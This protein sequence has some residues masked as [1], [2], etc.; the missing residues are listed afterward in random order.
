MEF[1]KTLLALGVLSV[2][3]GCGSDS[4]D[5]QTNTKKE[6]ESQVTSNEIK[7]VAA[8]GTLINAPVTFFKYENGQPVQ[9]DSQTAVITDE[10]GL[11]NATVNNAQ[12]IVK[13]QISVSQDAQNPTYM[14]CDAP[15][16]C[17]QNDTDTIAFGERVNLTQIAPDLVLSTFV[18][19]TEQPSTANITPLT[20]F[21]AAIAQQRG[22]VTPD[23]IAT[24]YSEI[25]DLFGLVGALH[26]MKPAMIED[27]ASLVDDNNSDDLRYA[28]INAG[29]AHALFADLGD[30][31]NALSTR[32]AEAITDIQAT[33]G[34]FLSNSAHDDDASF[35]FNLSDILA[36]AELASQQLITLIKADPALADKLDNLSELE[37]LSTRLHNEM[38][39]AETQ[40]TDRIKG[41]AQQQSGDNAVAK[42]AAMVQDIRVFANLFDVADTHGK[43]VRTQ[44]DEFVALIDDATDMV[45][46]QAN[47]YKLLADVSEALALIDS[48]R[49]AGQLPNNNQ[50]IKLD[51]YLELAGAT[52]MAVIDETG[53]VFSVTASAG[54]EQLEAN[55]TIT[56]AED[57][58]TYTLS[59][60]GKVENN[61]A[62]LTINQ[63][64]QIEVVL[65][66][67]VTVEQLKQGNAPAVD[68][69]HGSLALDVTIAQKATESITV[70]VSFQGMISAELTAKHIE[71]LTQTSLYEGLSGRYNF[72]IRPDTIFVPGMLSLSG[73]FSAAQGNQIGASLTVKLDN[74]SEF[75]PA[76]FEHFG[77]LIPDAGTLSIESD[78]KAKI[79][80]RD[81][82]SLLIEF[83]PVNQ[84]GIA[85]VIT[86]YVK[87]GEDTITHNRQI[88]SYQG[89][90][91]VELTSDYGDGFT[92]KRLE[93]I[94]PDGFGRFELQYFRYQASSLTG[95]ANGVVTFESGERI[96]VDE[97]DWRA[98]FSSSDE[99]ALKKLRRFPI[100][101]TRIE[102]IQ[103]LL[104]PEHSGSVYITKLDDIYVDFQLQQ[105]VYQAG[106]NYPLSARYLY[107]EIPHTIEVDTRS[108]GNA[109]TSTLGDLEQSWT[110]SSDND[111]AA[112]YHY[113]VTHQG[114]P[115]ET[116]SVFVKAMTQQTDKNDLIISTRYFD[117]FNDIDS[118]V[119]AYLQPDASGEGYTA[120]FTQ[121]HTL[122]EQGLPIDESGSYIDPTQHTLRTVNYVNYMHA[123][124]DI[125]GTELALGAQGYAQYEFEKKIYQEHTLNYPGYGQVNVVYYQT[126]NGEG[127][128]ATRSIGK[129]NDTYQIET[130]TNYLDISAAMNVNVKLGE[131]HVDLSLVGQRTDFKA[132]ELELEVD[133]QVPG[134]ELKRSFTVFYNTETEQ[135]SANNAEGV[136]LQMAETHSDD[137]EG[138][139]TLGTIMVG[140]EQAARIVK[141][142]AGLFI[143]YA[144]EQIE[145]L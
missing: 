2:L 41:Q 103:T 42:A 104:T 27:S 37:K 121:P 82:E 54:E 26:Q 17:G 84:Q 29:I 40:N 93:R 58:Q 94:V 11:F 113:S 78:S 51:D 73:T 142:D 67:P 139:Q 124:Q 122:N 72:S 90:D 145:T 60:S 89:V 19:V 50:P 48:A 10:N 4:N 106:Q 79:T 85:T 28:L 6:P 8:K 110:S 91:Y 138:E 20:H 108:D 116:M 80:S 101:Y 56:V 34:A 14:I 3:S 143:V 130:D 137:S 53:L 136:T 102:N 76:G 55:A 7:G 75:N 105:Q 126:W 134:S 109:I 87:D 74:L 69:R 9:L 135:L 99:V 18:N 77:R 111:T 22:E 38:L 13:A 100:D 21:A 71:K 23:S 43:E 15:A 45:R 35:E 1:K 66:Q 81:G 59:V 123:V 49:R 30:E 114:T 61:A 115:I 127:Y 119:A 96:A 47:S 70:P 128:D 16:G 44:G 32:L 118:S 12:G 24:A 64:S 46:D 129:P 131:Y 39:S 31:N 83:Q 36:G 92:T 140:E 125:T 5:S 144:N 62:A 95:Y 57:N 112:D 65:D 133:Y 88:S 63:G 97:L 52:G 120:Y 117:Q 33:D 25:A 86:Q 98:W 132:G 68:G 107:P 141:R